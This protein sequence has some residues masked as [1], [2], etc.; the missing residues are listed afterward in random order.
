M[1]LVIGVGSLVDERVGADGAEGSFCGFG[2]AFLVEPS[3]VFVHV[4][5]VKMA[6]FE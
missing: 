6:F 3:S 1:I 2:T 5:G 4:E